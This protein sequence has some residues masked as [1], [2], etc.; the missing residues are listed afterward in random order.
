MI[1]WK[2]KKRYTNIKLCYRTGTEVEQSERED[3]LRDIILMQEQENIPIVQEI[4]FETIPDSDAL[5]DSTYNRRSEKL[6]ADEERDKLLAQMCKEL[7][8]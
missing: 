5:Q 3:L 4:G 1:F 6:A 8:Q 2:G 7:V